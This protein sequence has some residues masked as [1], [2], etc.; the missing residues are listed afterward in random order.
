VIIKTSDLY[1]EKDWKAVVA[2]VITAFNAAYEGGDT[3]DYDYLAQEGEAIQI[4]LVNDLAKNWEVKPGV[5]YGTL[6][7][8][9]GSILS[10]TVSDYELAMGSVVMN[11]TMTSKN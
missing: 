4:V 11:E 5:K 9:T 3:F 10:I 2:N 8:K 1:L 6:Y 7:I